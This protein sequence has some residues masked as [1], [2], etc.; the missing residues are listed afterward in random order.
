MLGMTEKDV[1]P[2]PGLAWRR[3]F[4]RRCL[5]DAEEEQQLEHDVFSSLVRGWT[6]VIGPQGERR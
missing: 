2:M 4:R 1:V 3:M 5:E 6:L